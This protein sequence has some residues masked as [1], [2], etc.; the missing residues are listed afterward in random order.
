[1][2]ISGRSGRLR[3]RALVLMLMT[4]LAGA[5]ASLAA[6]NAAASP[7]APSAPVRFGPVTLFVVRR[8]LGPFT[9]AQRAA[10]ITARLQQTA[11]QMDGGGVI[12]TVQNRSDRTDVLLNGSVVTTVSD[13]DATVAGLSRAALYN[14]VADDFRR[15]I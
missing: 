13:E 10:A 3:A 5:S 1:M 2:Q 14:D 9:A 7:T 11:D 8:G 4:L 15:A 12:V 6:S